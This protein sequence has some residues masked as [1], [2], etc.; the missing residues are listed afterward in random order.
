VIQQ[1]G[2]LEGPS[3][4]P[5]VENPNG[6][7]GQETFLKV[8]V[9]QLKAQN[10]LSPANSGEYLGELVSLTELEQIT[11]LANAGQLSGAV[12]LIG[13]TVTYTAG[14]EKHTGTVEKVQ[15]S[16]AGVTVTVSGQGGVALNQLTEIS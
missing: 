2:G 13:H 11:N 12:G 5:Q 9:A 14:A 16:N 6:A 7:L 8:M 10:P 15:A 1:I 4:A 3:T